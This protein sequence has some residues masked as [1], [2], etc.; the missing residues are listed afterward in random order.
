MKRALPDL[1]LYLVLDPVLCGGAEGMIK[2][3]LLA[4]KAGA[5]CIQLRAPGW[6]TEEVIRCGKELKSV[7][8]PL[9]SAL[10]VNN[11]AIAAR[12]I[13]ATGLHV[14]QS[15]ISPAEARKI[16]GDAALIGLSITSESDIPSLD[17]ACVDYAGV[18]P[19]WTT[20]TKKDAAAAMGLERFKRIVK[21]LS[22]PSVAIG[23]IG[24]REARELRG[25]GAAGIA[26]VSAICGRPDV[27]LA[28]KSL[29]EAFTLSV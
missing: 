7:L 11:D 20:S 8:D 10:I 22:V 9:G 28:T 6:S 5:N 21:L 2:T 25:S 18:G 23:G 3:A 13:G 27:A 12:E 4:A 24:L 19:V 1:S 29:R 17:P 15:D 26:V 16:L 14:G